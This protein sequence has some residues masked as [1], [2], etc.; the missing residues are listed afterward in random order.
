MKLGL[1]VSQHQLTWPQLLERVR[2]AEDAGFDGVWLFDHFKAL[3]GDPTGPCMEAWTLMAAL[4]A[5]TERIRFGALVTG[6]TYRHPSILAAEAVTVDHVSSGRL[7]IGIGA[8]WFDGEHREL[9]IDF[10]AAPE[11]AHRL[12]EAIQVMKALMTTDGANFDGRYYQL[13]DATYRPRPVQ[14]PHP[15]IWVGAGGERLTI[16]IAARHADVWHGFGSVDTLIRK[17]AIVDEHAALAGRDPSE[18]ARSTNL[19][20]SEPINEVRDTALAVQ[21]AGFSYLIASW[22]AD[23]QPR[24]EEFL[25]KVAPELS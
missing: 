2:F 5:A 18:I 8:A 6:V 23:G 1:D 10:P 16:P 19:S 4:A 20:L 21:D 14:Q 17:S 3:Y 7:E 25:G 12:E 11:R 13:D 9:G 24:V 15:P 22:P